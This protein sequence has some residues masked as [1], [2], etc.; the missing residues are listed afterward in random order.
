MADH[1]VHSIRDILFDD[2]RSVH[3]FETILPAYSEARLPSYTPA[4]PGSTLSRFGPSSVATSSRTRM[5]LPPPV[6][7]PQI[8]SIS[9]S[10]LPLRFNGPRSR[11]PQY[12]SPKSAYSAS[13]PPKKRPGAELNICFRNGRPSTDPLGHGDMSEVPTI[14]RRSVSTRAPVGHSF[15]EEIRMRQL[16]SPRRRTQSGSPTGATAARPSSAPR[17]TTTSRRGS[18]PSARA[19]RGRCAQANSTPE[20]S[21][22]SRR[23]GA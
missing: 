19:A 20:A 11:S 2:A 22:N 12:R 13:S 1:S 17:N 5:G 8:L 18:R 23:V 16:D 14:A 10:N 3:S 15:D 21:S 6:P 9:Q 7:T 4:A